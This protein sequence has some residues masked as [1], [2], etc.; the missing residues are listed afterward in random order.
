MKCKVESIQAL[1]NTQKQKKKKQY[2]I[3]IHIQI[4]EKKK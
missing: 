1:A 3:Y 2:I 4:N